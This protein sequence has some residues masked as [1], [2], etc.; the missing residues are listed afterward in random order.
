[1]MLTQSPQRPATAGLLGG[2]TYTGAW[3]GFL[4]T[5]ATLL[6]KLDAQLEDAHALSLSSFEVL[7]HLSWAPGH[8][9]PMGE[10]AHKS[11]LFSHSSSGLRRSLRRLEAEGLVRRE[12]PCPEE[13]E[14]SSGSC[15][16]LTEAGL[17]RLCEAHPTH[18]S[19]VREHFFEHFTEGELRAMAK[20]WRRVLSGA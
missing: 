3:S 11:V 7:L 5:H 16:V 6:R 10:L 12:K 15:V 9:M 4:R 14:R 19:G 17:D 2:I 8:R 20:C 18:L 1:M 13:K